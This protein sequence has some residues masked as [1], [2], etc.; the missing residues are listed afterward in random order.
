MRSGGSKP[1]VNATWG[2]NPS[3]ERDL[4]NLAA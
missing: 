4:L 3:S 2:A 1:H